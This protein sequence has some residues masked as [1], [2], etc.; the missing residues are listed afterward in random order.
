[1][2]WAWAVVPVLVL[3]A[4]TVKNA[5]YAIHALPPLSVWAAL[6]LVRVG[7]RLVG[8]RAWSPGRVRLAA[9][10]LFVAMGL[11]CG[12]GHLWLGPRFDRRGP[13][14]AWCE[15]IGRTLGPNLPLV[16]LYEDW[17]RKPYPTPFG[18][19]PHDWAVRLYYLGRPASW[20]QGVGDLAARSRQLRAMQEFLDEAVPLL[21]SGKDIEAFGDLLH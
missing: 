4:A 15:Q 18:P 16:F 20:R 1:M 6:G 7:D 3:S 12:L 8:R 11:G 21:R 5:H 10:A 13:E 9:A 14:W 17:D 2:L 19:V